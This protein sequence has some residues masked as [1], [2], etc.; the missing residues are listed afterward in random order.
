M[1]RDPQDFIAPVQFLRFAE[2]T[3]I[4]YYVVGLQKID[5]CHTCAA[6]EPRVQDAE[7]GG[8]R[9]YCQR[10]GQRAANDRLP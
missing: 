7:W 4:C 8:S 3:G 5:L 2:Q 9:G 10:C 6:S 1:I